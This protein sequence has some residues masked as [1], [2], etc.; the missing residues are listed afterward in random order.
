MIAVTPCD[1]NEVVRK[2][3]HAKTLPCRQGA[4]LPFCSMGN[5]KS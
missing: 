2:I 5:P 4:R 3:K 1:I